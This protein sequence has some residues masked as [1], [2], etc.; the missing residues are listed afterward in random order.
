[1]H[2]ACKLGANLRF[3]TDD[4]D[5]ECGVGES[6]EALAGNSHLEI[7]GCVVGHVTARVPAHVLPLRLRARGPHFFAGSGY[8]Y[9]L[10]CK[11]VNGFTLYR[12]PLLG[13]PVQHGLSTLPICL[14]L[15]RYLDHHLS[16]VSRYSSLPEMRPAHSTLFSHVRWGC[17]FA[18]FEPDAL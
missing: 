6:F 13:S 10:A 4:C 12:T 2:E 1:M 16:R 11:T 7:Q 17:G 14:F 5:L 3:A 15:Y 18:S 8:V 9:I